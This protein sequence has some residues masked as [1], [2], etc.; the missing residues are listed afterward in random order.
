MQY[1]A[2]LTDARSKTKKGRLSAEESDEL[3]SN[4][5]EELAQRI[6]GGEL[7]DV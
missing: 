1:L 4:F 7:P 3:A 2:L 5:W 6:A